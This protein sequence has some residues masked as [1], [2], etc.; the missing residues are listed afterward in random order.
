V[1][2]PL[3]VGFL[4]DRLSRAGTETQLLALIRALDRTRVRPFLYLLDGTDAESRALEPADCPVERLGLTSF[5]RPGALA[6]AARMAARFRRDRLD[7]LQTYFLDSTY[8]GV[9]LAKLAGVRRVV[10]VRN[11]LGEWLTV[12]HR[13]LGLLY[14]RLADVTLTNS[15]AGRDA[16]RRVERLHP[17]RLAVLEN[18][19]DL[20]RFL[21]TPPPDFRHAD[22]L[23]VG[24]LA[25]LRPV[26]NL[27]AL[28]EAAAAL[29]P[30][31][32]GLR[33][34]VAGDGPQRPDLERL[35]AEHGLAGRFQLL[36]PVADVPAFL[37]RQ[38]VAVL[39]SLAEGM[40]NALL[41]YMAAARP[42]VATAVGAA[43]DLIRDGEEGLL[44]PPGDAA[45]LTAAL[46]RVLGEPVLAR[47][48]GE[49]ARRRVRE[50]HGRAAMRWRFEQFYDAL[51]HGRR[52]AA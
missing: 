23:R 1:T 24:A 6:R 27:P 4:I 8:L 36:G 13:L 44:V 10:R 12:K 16:L 35:I 32:P 31:F 19:V 26:K 9:P 43:T 20:D 39:C 3:H 33:V 37:A 29:A 25:N 17:R 40:S 34:Q 47:R 50:R 48:L 22:V 42:V 49:S 11:N 30:R 52:R 41:E 28:V 14:G 2:R 21:A 51:C 5:R 15:A 7:V 18:G 45:A 38:D 46:G